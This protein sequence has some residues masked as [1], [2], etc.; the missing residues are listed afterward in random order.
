MMKDKSQEMS[1]VALDTM[2]GNLNLY[3]ENKGVQLKNF[4]LSG[5]R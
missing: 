2:L 4:F 3:F 1:R 5:R